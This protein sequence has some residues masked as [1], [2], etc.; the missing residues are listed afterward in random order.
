MTGQQGR[1]GERESS[2]IRLPALANRHPPPP[3]IFVGFTHLVALLSSPLPAPSC[4]LLLLPASILLPPG[5]P[6][7]AYPLLLLPM[8][9]HP[10]CCAR[11]TSCC[12]AHNVRNTR[13]EERCKN[14]HGVAYRE[15]EV[16]YDRVDI[17]GQ[18]DDVLV[19]KKR[20][21]LRLRVFLGIVVQDPWCDRFGYLGRVFLSL[22][23]KP[24]HPTYSDRKDLFFK[25]LKIMTRGPRENL[26][27]VQTCVVN[28][29]AEGCE[30]IR[31]YVRVRMIHDAT[32]RR[33]VANLF[34]I[35]W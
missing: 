32:K 34:R 19:K 28:V 10:P 16:K 7:L 2:V 1:G 23:F 9:G 29:A 11:A 15:S 17:F 18:A 27:D 6:T 14:G 33:P 24:R 4:F 26:F 8:T 22:F 30:V 25:P 35:S 12:D 3:Q 13:V 20:Q 5:T 21:R 31:G